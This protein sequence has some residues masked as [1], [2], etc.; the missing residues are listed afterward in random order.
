MGLFDGMFGGGQPMPINQD[1]AA[2]LQQPQQGAG[3]FGQ[4]GGL[5]GLGFGG[6]SNQPIANMGGQGTGLL[7]FGSPGQG[8]MNPMMKFGMGM[9]G[10]GGGMPQQ[11]MQQPGQMPQM[12]MPQQAPMQMAGMQAP[13]TTIN[14][15]L[16]P[17]VPGMRSESTQYEQARRAA[18]AAAQPMGVLGT[19][20]WPDEAHMRNAARAPFLR[21][22]GQTG[23]Y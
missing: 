5:M 19:L 13:P 3:M 21:T 10:Q 16:Q 9:M 6:Q 11:Q 14:N 22:M 2:M 23:P 1:G 20:V 18:D 12:P 17:P 7:G 4:G 15:G 8:G